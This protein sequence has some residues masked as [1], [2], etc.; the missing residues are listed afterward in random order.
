MDHHSGLARNGEEAVDDAAHRV[1]A[2]DVAVVVEAVDRRRADA[3][4]VVNG[5]EGAVG[6]DEAVRRGLA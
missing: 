4:R 5:P 1:E 3:M 6:P 2:D